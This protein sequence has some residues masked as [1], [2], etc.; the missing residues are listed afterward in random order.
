VASC[1]TR[2]R[3]PATAGVPCRPFRCGRPHR[4]GSEIAPLPA[5]ALARAV[6]G[7]NGGPRASAR[8]K[9][10]GASAS[11]AGRKPSFITVSSALATG[12]RRSPSAG[13]HAPTPVCRERSLVPFHSSS[14]RPLRPSI[15]YAD[16]FYIFHR[17]GTLKSPV[18]CG[19]DPVLVRPLRG[20]NEAVLQF[21]S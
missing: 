15:V 2:G 6:V 1:G 10:S 11:F 8:T 19:S 13:G 7:S 17:R 16:F 21:I 4:V 9:V 20:P 5:K 3:H 12:G 18:Q 14:Q